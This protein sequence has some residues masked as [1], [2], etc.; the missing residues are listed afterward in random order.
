MMLCL[1]V[2]E[3]NKTMDQIQLAIICPLCGNPNE[4]AQAVS[5][6]MEADCWCMHVVIPAEVLARIPE[7]KLG[8][9]CICRLCAEIPA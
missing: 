8:K 5:S 3:S 2:T 1:G 9:V 4:C 6:G 7:D